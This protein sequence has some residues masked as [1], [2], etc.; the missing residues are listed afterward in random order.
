MS[1]LKK[2]MVLSIVLILF[3]FFSAFTL[4]IFYIN[5]GQEALAQNV[6]DDTIYL[7]GE[8]KKEPEIP[9]RTD[10]PPN[11]CGEHHDCGCPI[12]DAAYGRS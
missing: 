9:I 11:N 2:R 4:S 1:F 8:A 5:S 10:P 6:T 7:W 3:I 12:C